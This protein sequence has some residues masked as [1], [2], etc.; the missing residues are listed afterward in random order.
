MLTLEETTPMKLVEQ[1]IE[2][3]VDGDPFDRRASVSKNDG[4]ATI[5]SFGRQGRLSQ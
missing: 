3:T 1:I 4:N 5:S 2:A